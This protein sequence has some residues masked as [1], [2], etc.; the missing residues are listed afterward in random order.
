[1]CPVKDTSRRFE[2]L[3]AQHLKTAGWFRI[4]TL[5]IRPGEADT[6]IVPKLGPESP[7][8]PYRGHQ[9]HSST[10]RCSG[11]RANQRST[12]AF[13][14][15][16]GPALS[17]R[18]AFPEPRQNENPKASIRSASQ[19]TRPRKTWTLSTSPKRSQVRQR[20]HPI[21][22]RRMDPTGRTRRKPYAPPTPKQWSRKTAAP[23]AGQTPPR[24]SLS[25]KPLQK[26]FRR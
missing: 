14:N 25:L 7:P 20:C 13:Q 19:G 6:D 23:T 12:A 16:P 3:A 15:S 4:R 10:N 1:M 18:P 21:A 8:S 5:D 24:E 2:S 17:R 22:E 26:P 9:L 11:L